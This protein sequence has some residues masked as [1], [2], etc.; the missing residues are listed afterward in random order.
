MSGVGFERVLTGFA[1]VLVLTAGGALADADDT[2][3]LETAVTEEGVPIPEAANVPAP[4]LTDIG[5]IRGSV[6]TGPTLQ[7][8]EKAPEAKETAPAPTT[9]ASTPAPKE[10]P[11]PA[12]TATIAAP[13]TDVPFPEPANVP[14]PT[15]KD[16]G[17]AALANLGAV[18]LPIA[19][20][21]RDKVTGGLARV[22][23]RKKDRDAVI[24]FYTG[25]LFAPLWIENGA[26]N[27][28]AKSVTAQLAA[29]D[30]EGLDP[31]DYPRPDFKAGAEPD[32][33]ADAELKL[34]VSVLNYARHAQTG[35]AHYSR[36]ASDIAYNLVY[37][38]PAD[39]LT[40]MAETKN[41]GDA[42]TAYNPP[43]DGYKALKA[44]LAEARG[45]KIDAGPARIASGP[46][47]KVGMNDGRVPQLRERLGVS[48]ESGTTY[49]K[50][51]SEAVKKFQRGRD[52]SPT[53]T[54]TSA[55]VD[56]LNGGGGRQARHREADIIIANMERWRWLPRDLGKAHV[57]LN[58]PNYTLKVMKDGAPIWNTK[59]VVGKAHTPTPI[60]TETM[61]YI[62]V[63]PTWNVPPSIVQ[64]E[65]LPALAQDPT[66]LA[67][68]GLKV[69]YN[70]D[71]SI[72]ISQPPGDGNALGRI[73]FNFPNKFLVYQHDTPD[74]HL[75]AHDRR[76]YSHG[77]MR[78]EN[79]FKYGEVLLSI[80]LPKENYTQER[81]RR[82]IG[83][84]EQNITFPTPIPVHITYQTAFV[85]EHG[86]L[87][88]R[89]DIY[90]R[91][92]RT[93]AALRGEERRYADIAVE[94]RRADNGSRPQAARLPGGRPQQWNQGYSFLDR[95]FR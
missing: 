6:D 20:K 59:V 38:E 53:G 87:V 27:A 19:E 26:A 63:N 7:A 83:S 66:V 37:P 70:R 56:A 65:Y 64:N 80:A 15:V 73:R 67:R 44:K 23:D 31:A 2:T 49:D 43:H 77:C 95:L 24:A 62:T 39:I 46:V 9:T 78:V 71:G 72:H 79:P 91:D 68:M 86:K 94:H 47:L 48:G 45:Q 22:V 17:K 51:L 14:P 90:G 28:R 58:I 11:A 33:L 85:D 57:M 75:F 16:I 12:A 82:M 13:V 30:A 69:S 93:L 61:K 92:S 40:N 18:D 5:P 84:S 25:R 81:L 52:L 41:A 29:A 74:K 60:L 35:R 3:A 76:S 21:L 54:L 88:L 34:T 42:L 8:A 89:E 36:I 32:A 1:L 4:T 50:A 55:T 10:E